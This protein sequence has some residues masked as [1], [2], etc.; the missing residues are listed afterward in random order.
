MPS[1]HYNAE[2]FDAHDCSNESQVDVHASNR[3]GDKGDARKR[4]LSKREVTEKTTRP[5]LPKL[6]KRPQDQTLPLLIHKERMADNNRKFQTKA[7]EPPCVYGC[8]LDILPWIACFVW[9]LSIF[10]G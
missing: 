1:G 2:R 7:E 5:N 8:M 3:G 4:H 6:L 9:I 10:W